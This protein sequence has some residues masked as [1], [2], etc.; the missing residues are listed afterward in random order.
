MVSRISRDSGFPRA[1]GGVKLIHFGGVKLIRPYVQWSPV[2]L[3]RA[4]FGRAFEGAS[5]G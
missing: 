2:Y 3:L 5:A 1:F 4:S